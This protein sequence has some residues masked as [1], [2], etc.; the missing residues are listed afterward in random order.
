MVV[1][2]KK[3]SSSSSF[4]PPGSFFTALLSATGLW[5]VAAGKLKF[6]AKEEDATVASG[7]ELRG[8]TAM[9]DFDEDDGTELA[10]MSGIEARVS[11]APALI[12]WMS[13]WAWEGVRGTGLAAAISALQSCGS[14]SVSFVLDP[15]IYLVSGSGTCLFGSGFGFC[16]S[17]NSFDRALLKGRI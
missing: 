13:A 3:N 16:R 17:Y 9:S 10:D 11:A 5:D 2:S 6:L 8:R 12:V 15:D 7:R 14:G 4:S 1:L